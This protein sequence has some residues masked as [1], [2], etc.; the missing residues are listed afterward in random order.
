M[1]V[2]FITHYAEMM[3]TNRSMVQLII[4]LMGKGVKLFT[5]I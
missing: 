3:G 4:E 1:K 2:L 5:V